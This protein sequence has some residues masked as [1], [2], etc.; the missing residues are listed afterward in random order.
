MG[1][2]RV[3]GTD[4]QNV[5]KLF[6]CAFKLAQVRVTE[7]ACCLN[8]CIATPNLELSKKKKTEIIPETTLSWWNP[9]LEP[10]A[11]KPRNWTAINPLTKRFLVANEAISC[12]RFIKRV[13]GRSISRFFAF[14]S[15]NGIHHDEVVSGIILMMDCDNRKFDETSKQRNGLKL[16]ISIV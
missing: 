5:L 4:K 10:N 1:L 6:N 9:L 15:N 16:R 7:V 12:F 13:Y 11:K 14:D 8:F 2:G 3:G